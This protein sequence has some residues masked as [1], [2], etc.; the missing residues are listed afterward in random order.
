MVVSNQNVNYS[1]PE[2]Y[3]GKWWLHKKLE[4]DNFLY[5]LRDFFGV[6]KTDFNNNAIIKYW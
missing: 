2:T 5:V 4:E 6:F 3:L 1:N